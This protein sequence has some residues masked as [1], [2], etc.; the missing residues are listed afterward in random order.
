MPVK[1][2]P[3]V[4]EP[5]IPARMKGLRSSRK[6]SFLQKGLPFVMSKGDVDSLWQSLW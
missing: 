1:D 6:G 4:E 5:I 2:L 3:F